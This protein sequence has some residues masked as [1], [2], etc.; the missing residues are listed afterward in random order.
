MDV[1]AW[2]RG[3]LQTP[4]ISV[5]EVGVIGAVGEL[6]HVIR[7]RVL[8]RRKRA[9]RLQ[10]FCHR[11]AGWQ[12]DKR[13]TPDAAEAPE[14]AGSYAGMRFGDCCFGCASMEFYED[15]VRHGPPRIG[16]RGLS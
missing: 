12:P 10:G 9:V 2:L 14:F 5:G 6:A 4:K 7:R 15:F 13:K 11:F 3:I 8:D 1:H 16:L